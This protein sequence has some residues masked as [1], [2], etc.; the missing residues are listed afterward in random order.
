[1]LDLFKFYILLTWFIYSTT[2]LS[3]AKSDI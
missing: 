2:G 3:E 1:M